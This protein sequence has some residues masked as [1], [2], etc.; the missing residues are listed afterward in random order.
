MSYS[1]AGLAVSPI[2]DA[3]RKLYGVTAA[4]GEDIDHQ[5]LR[6]AVE[7]ADSSFFLS[8]PRYLDSVNRGSGMGEEPSRRKPPRD[9]RSV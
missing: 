6:S 8:L 5:P 2:E 4:G 9:F 1:E 7:S 3:D